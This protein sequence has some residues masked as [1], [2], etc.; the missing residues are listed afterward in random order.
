M[1]LTTLIRWVWRTGG[2]FR[3]GLDEENKW[4]VVILRTGKPSA[5][6]RAA[7]LLVFGE[8]HDDISTVVDRAATAIKRTKDWQNYDASADDARGRK[9]LADMLADDSSDGK[10]EEVIEYNYD[11]W[12]KRPRDLRGKLIGTEK[13]GE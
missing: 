10:R 4:Q 13:G 3:I 6:G 2:S 1:N 8:S 7:A 5:K 11:I 9:T 12:D